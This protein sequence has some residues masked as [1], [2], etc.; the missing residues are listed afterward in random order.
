MGWAFGIESPPNEQML[1]LGRDRR[2]L[3]RS[4]RSDLCHSRVHALRK[5][6]IDPAATNWSEFK[7]KYLRRNRL[8]EHNEIYKEIQRT[9]QIFM[10]FG[11]PR[12]GLGY[13][14]P[15]SWNAEQKTHAGCRWAA[16]KNGR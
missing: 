12:D 7:L 2:R 9:L 10:E 11:V 1:L 5:G 13:E 16:N 15:E 14:F 4:A 6:T 8:Q 3:A